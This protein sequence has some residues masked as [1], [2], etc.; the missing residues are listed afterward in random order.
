MSKKHVLH[1]VRDWPQV[2]CKSGTH[3]SPDRKPDSLQFR[4]LLSSKYLKRELKKKFSKILLQ[5]G[6][7]ETGR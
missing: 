2:I 7:C 1:E 5:I 4:S 3:E 6:K